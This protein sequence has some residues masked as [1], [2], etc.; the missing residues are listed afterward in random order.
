MKT[1]FDI[2]DYGAIADGITDC[3]K[4]IQ[5]AIDDA[6]RVQGE[7]FVP[8]GV[9][10]CGYLK[11]HANTTIKGIATWGYRRN[12]GSILKLNDKN[13]KCMLD[14][15]GAFD[16]N[17]TGLCLD[18][19]YL[20]ENINGIMM[21]K[22][23]CFSFG[24]EDTPKIENCRISNFSGNGVHY[25]NVWCFSIRHSEMGYN[26][27]HGMY[28][29]GCDGFIIDCWFSDNYKSG[30]YATES[31]ASITFTSNRFECNKFAG[32]EGKSGSYINMTGNYFDA[33]RGPGILLDP[34]GEF[35]VNMT[36]TGN[37][38]YRDGLLGDRN[39]EKT[40]EYKD[41][42]IYEYLS[43]HIYMEK[44]ANFTIVGNTFN[45]GSPKD[46]DVAE[47]YYGI[48]YKKLKSCVIKDNVMECGAGKANLLDL[49][50]HEGNVIVKDNVG[51][52]LTDFRC[53]WPIFE[54][55]KENL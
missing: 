6:S 33:N 3:T 53:H 11:M 21:D 7:V 27:G 31:A 49:G 37:I 9:F 50:N 32:F 29:Q 8:A 23:D 51:N 20:G 1:T 47:P 28:M 36:V 54:D 42:P 17:I 26:K 10:L 4:A 30:F 39:E 12:G 41:T 38:F 2:T 24:F 35:R 5:T 15:T 48:V 55:Y 45:V 14:I 43:S 16:C 25:H 18:G 40:D 13:V 19:D 46:T 44:C 22:R 34:K 52:I